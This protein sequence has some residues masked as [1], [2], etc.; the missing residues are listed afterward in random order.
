MHID[1]RYEVTLSKI[2]VVTEIDFYHQTV[3]LLE[4]LYSALLKC[5]IRKK[6][7]IKDCCKSNF[8][9][10]F[11]PFNNTLSWYKI[12]RKIMQI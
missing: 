12:L 4:S 2:D 8:L 7:S 1:V 9:D 6:S 5:E 11:T 3:G 10:A